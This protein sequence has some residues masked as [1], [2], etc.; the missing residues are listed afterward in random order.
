[1]EYT[2]G[3]LKET[4][5]YQTTPLHSQEYE[6]AGNSYLMAIV[7]I[8]MGLPLPILNLIAAGGYYLAYRKAAYFVR[9]HCIQ[10]AIGQAVLIP[11]NSIAVAW[12]L[13]LF[14]RFTSFT[15]EDIDNEAQVASQTFHGFSEA[16]A[17][18]WLYIIFIVVLNITE[19]IVVISTASK[20]KDGHNVR[21]WL[22][23][24]I[25]DRLCSKEDRN[26]YKVKGQ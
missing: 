6:Q 21:W 26:P 7:A 12:T 11:F 8:I 24:P 23:A 1:M 10:S 5:N 22:I 17:A 25:V 2:E 20:V 18:Y 4:P 19:F 16:G 9:W 13:G 3:T 14:M 15:I